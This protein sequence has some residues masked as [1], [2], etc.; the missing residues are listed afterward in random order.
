[1]KA[2]GAKNSQIFM[3]FFVESGFLGLVGGLLGAIFG[4]LIGFVGTVGINSWLGSEIG[5]KIDYILI[6][7]TLLGSFLIGAIAGIIPAMQAAKQNPVEA[8]RG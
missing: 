2:V 1:M 7:F 3:Q 5:F 8:L 4:I 6:F